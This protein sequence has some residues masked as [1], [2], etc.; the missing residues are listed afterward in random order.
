M[1]GRRGARGEANV[2]PI[3]HRDAL[4]FETSQRS[5]R[6]DRAFRTTGESVMEEPE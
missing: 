6:D 4:A 2:Q 3:T 5:A 1:N